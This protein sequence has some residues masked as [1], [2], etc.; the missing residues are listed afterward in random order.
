MNQFPQ[1]QDSQKAIKTEKIDMIKIFIMKKSLQSKNNQ[2]KY[3]LQLI[4][5]SIKNNSI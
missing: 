5:S 2:M 4:Y 3:S 1:N